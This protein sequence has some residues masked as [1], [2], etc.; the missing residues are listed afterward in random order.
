MIRNLLTGVFL[1][2]TVVQQA[3]VTVAARGPGG[4]NIEG[5]SAEVS[6][7]QEASVLIFKLPI[8]PIDT[9]IELRN[10]HLRA[11]LETDRFP[12]AS[13]RVSRADLTF[14]TTASPV[15]GTVTGELTLHGQ[16]RPVA[17]RYR[18]LRVAGLTRL[19]GSVR[20]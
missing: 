12:V 13:L 14:P 1:L 8:D 7:E 3:A 4:L 2:A 19:H 11:S 10:R 9:G 17:V 6:L 18:A 20:V 15:A 16:T 5:N